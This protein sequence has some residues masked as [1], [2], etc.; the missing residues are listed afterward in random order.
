MCTITTICIVLIVFLWKILDTEDTGREQFSLSSVILNH[1]YSFKV[2]RFKCWNN[3]WFW[4][5][6]D[7]LISLWSRSS[8]LMV[9]NMAILLAF[10][11]CF[12]VISIFL[13]LP[14]CVFHN[15]IF[16]IFEFF[17][18]TGYLKLIWWGLHSQLF[19]LESQKGAHVFSYK[20]ISHVI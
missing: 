3:E 1:N 13:C 19:T 18:S 11:T 10:P 9:M 17:M 6:R 14:C 16:V 2:C 7:L 20:L 5:F 12:T 8:Y 4:N 15:C